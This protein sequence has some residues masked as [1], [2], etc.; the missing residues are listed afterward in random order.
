VD[1]YQKRW[2]K[3]VASNPGLTRTGLRSKALK[4]YTFLRRHAPQWLDS[5]SPPEK[6]NTIVASHVDWA[7]RDEDISSEIP[8]AAERLLHRE[9]LVRLTRTAILREAGVV[10]ALTKL[11]RLPET[12]TQL[13]RREETRINFA[14]RRI[15]YAN[16][17]F[18]P[19]EQWKLIRAA[20]LRP[21]LVSNPVVAAAL[22]RA[23]F[24]AEEGRR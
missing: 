3:L 6:I 23:L 11:S 24:L 8:R 12:D 4:I 19:L 7:A 5:N 13:S 10:W 16:T 15:E 2:L 9:P 21:D 22:K 14:I 20:N 1:E 17:R 18:S